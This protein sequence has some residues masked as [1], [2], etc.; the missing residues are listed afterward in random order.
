MMVESLEMETNAQLRKGLKGMKRVA[1]D[2]SWFRDTP[3]YW[4]EASLPLAYAAICAEVVSKM[5][6]KAG[7]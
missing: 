6:E 2:G 1:D 5:S 3:H 7:Y 4:T